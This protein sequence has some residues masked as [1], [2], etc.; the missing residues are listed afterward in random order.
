MVAICVFSFQELLDAGGSVG[1][2]FFSFL[3]CLF[4]GGAS[5]IGTKRNEEYVPSGKLT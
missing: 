1:G 3:P 2:G 4:F 5:F